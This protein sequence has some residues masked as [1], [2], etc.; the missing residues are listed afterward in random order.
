MVEQRQARASR[1]DIFEFNAERVLGFA[2]ASTKRAYFFEFRDSHSVVFLLDVDHAE[3]GVA[4]VNARL[5][6]IGRNIQKMVEVLLLE[7]Y[8]FGLAMLSVLAS[9][10]AVLFRHANMVG[11]A[12]Y[13]ERSLLRLGSVIYLSIG[14]LFKNYKGLSTTH[15]P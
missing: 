15:H 10:R 12:A 3:M 2:L 14:R 11:G 9:G 8:A 13:I 6:P 7:H 1:P 5:V 4:A